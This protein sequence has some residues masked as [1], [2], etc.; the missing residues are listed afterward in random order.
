MSVAVNSVVLEMMF[1]IDE[2]YFCEKSEC[3]KFRCRHL[4]AY[5]TIEKIHL[6]DRNRIYLRSA[7]RDEALI[8]FIRDRSQKEM[9]NIILRKQNAQLNNV[10]INHIR[11]INL[12]ANSDVED[13]D[14]D[15]EKD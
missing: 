15:E 13:D 12:R 1:T 6:D 9:M 11:L 3:R 10:K 4:D 5:K 7:E 8:K 2:C 14:T